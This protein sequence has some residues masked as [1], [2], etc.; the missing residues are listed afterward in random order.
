[1][2]EFTK[3]EA[4]WLKF[5]GDFGPTVHPQNK[6]IKGYMHDG[7]TYLDS[8]DLMSMS[9]ALKSVA[10]WLNERSENEALRTTP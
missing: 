6:E 9:A 4:E 5:L 1:M 8:N 7:K 2:R 10:E 3:L